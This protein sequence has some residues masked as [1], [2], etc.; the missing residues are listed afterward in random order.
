MV[1][2]LAEEYFQSFLLKVRVLDDD[3]VGVGG[4]GMGGVAAAEVDT[5]G[6]SRMPHAISHAST[7]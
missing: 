3:G 4:V 6:G 2:A 1:V 5:E 7:L